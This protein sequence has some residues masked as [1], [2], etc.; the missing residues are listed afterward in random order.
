[1]NKKNIRIILNLYRLLPVYFMVRHGKESALIFDELRFW[2]KC[3]E[4]EM[5]NMFLAFSEMLLDRKEYRNL[6][7]YRIYN[8]GVL[9]R[10]L[11]KLFFPPLESLYIFAQKIGARFY[12]QHGFSTIINAKSIGS[13]CWI[14]QQVTVGYDFASEPPVIGNGVRISAGAKVIGDITVGDN[15]IIGAGAVVVKNVEKNQIGGGVPAKVIG[16]NKEHKLFPN[17][18]NV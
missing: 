1:M 12:I 4:K 18:E 6:L 8:D 9:S 13:N 17:Q 14:N 11:L 7:L 10:K 5:D 15:A 2:L 16:E 3:S